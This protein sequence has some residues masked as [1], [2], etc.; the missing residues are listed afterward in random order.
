M[1]IDAAPSA[2]GRWLERAAAVLTELGYEVVPPERGQGDLLNHLLVAIR[3]KPTESHFDPEQVDYWIS[4]GSRGHAARID[5]DARFPVAGELSWG[6]VTLTDRLG[7]H[8][9]FLT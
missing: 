1:T 5:R 3:A 4:D 2:D 9:E 7:V 6:S 8:N